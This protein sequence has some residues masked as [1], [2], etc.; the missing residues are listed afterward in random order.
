V[1]L[2]KGLKIG[3]TDAELLSEPK[4]R[5]RALLDPPANGLRVNAAKLCDL[6]DR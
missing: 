1:S 4:R 6:L 3:L 2:E 5:E